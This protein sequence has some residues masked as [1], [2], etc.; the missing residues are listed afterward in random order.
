MTTS[1]ALG[2][3]L[4]P[5]AF[6]YRIWVVI[7]IIRKLSAMMV[8][9]WGYLKMTF[10]VISRITQLTLCWSA[11][12]WLSTSTT[13][14]VKMNADSGVKDQHFGPHNKEESFNNKFL[15]G[16]FTNPMHIGLIFL[17]N[18]FKEVWNLPRSI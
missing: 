1:T 4:S 16:N 2:S 7:Q 14:L 6:T 13:P 18:K 12:Q 5:R 17:I 8:T 10:N 9:V 11:I 3:P 15:F